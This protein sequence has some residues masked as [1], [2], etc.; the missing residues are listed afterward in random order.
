MPD[1]RSVPKDLP[2]TV[3]RL[4]DRLAA[5][6]GAIPPFDALL[7]DDI[8][9]LVDRCIELSP[10]APAGAPPHG[11]AVAMAYAVYAQPHL[12][13]TLGNFP[14]QA[15]T[16]PVE[17]L[18]QRLS[19]SRAE[20]EQIR[21]EVDARA[22]LLLRQRRVVS[23]LAGHFGL[24]SPVSD[25]EGE[26][27]LSGPA[28][29][30]ALFPGCE[31]LRFVSFEVRD[32][33]IYAMV[34]PLGM[35]P[36]PSHLDAID[37]DDAAGLT[38]R[39]Q[40]RYVDRGIQRQLQRA[41]ALTDEEVVMI[42]DRAVALVPADRAEEWLELDRWRAEGLAGLSGL[43]E[44]IRLR[45][46]G[47]PTGP[48]GVAW[49]DWIVREGDR[50]VTTRSKANFDALAMR[51]VGELARLVYADLLAS[52]WSGRIEDASTRARLF[53]LEPA[54]EAVLQPLI[55][56]TSDAAT[57]SEIARLYSVDPAEVRAVLETVRREWQR[58]ASRGWGGRPS[59][60]LPATVLALFLV[61]LAA[62]E[63]SLRLAVGEDDGTEG[64]LM[65]F[66]GRWLASA[67]LGRLWL[68]PEG[69]L[70]APE[71]PVSQWFPLVASALVSVVVEA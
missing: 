10:R 60:Q 55:D 4:L 41:L 42:L 39:F 29:F 65:L 2:T 71:D 40:G 50:L 13:A 54:F 7:A 57:V 20:I 58:Q 51:R 8:G 45:G 15:L 63:S 3:T 18:E 48:D 62:L 17:V 70:P 64:V 34:A 49:S 31:D 61:H 52:A 66:L 24:R 22:V 26:L 59:A 44:T 21:D 56:W 33:R 11:A 9:V 36:D 16:V 19:L 47:G 14:E 25:E 27:R 28:A 1:H 46:L 6:R 68:T 38:G 69:D 43:D 67:P 5:R 35:S 23:W 12:V 37:A 32:L 30:H 53:D